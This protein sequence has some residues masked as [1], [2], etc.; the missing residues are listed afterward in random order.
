MES[1]TVRD[2]RN[3]GGEVLRRVEH[4]E[5]VVVTRDGMPVAELR[6]LPRPSVSAA[7]LIRR[8]EHLPPVGVVEF[9]RDIDDLIDPS[10]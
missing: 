2:L 1:V 4:G 10:L 8:R 5:R 9:R 7:E 3:N 6:P